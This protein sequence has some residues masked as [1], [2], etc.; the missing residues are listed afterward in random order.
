MQSYQRGHLG[1][2]RVFLCV[3]N[4][5]L[6]A[7]DEYGNTAQIW[8]AGHGHAD[9][10]ALLVEHKADVNARNHHQDTHGSIHYK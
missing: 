1:C 2:V 3:K 10:V 7:T 5:N 8:A 6:N 4:I 9:I